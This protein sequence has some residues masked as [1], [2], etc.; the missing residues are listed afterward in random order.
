MIPDIVSSHAAKPAT[1][2]VLQ[3]TNTLDG[4]WVVSRPAGLHRQPLSEPCVKL[5]PHTAPIRQTNRWLRYASGQ[6]LRPVSGLAA[7]ESGQLGWDA[8]QSA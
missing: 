3:R 8:P 4:E 7:L 6:R 2:Y 5:S 1:V